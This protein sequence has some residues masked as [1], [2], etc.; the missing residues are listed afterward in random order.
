MR[1]P[2]LKLAA[3]LIAAVVAMVGQTSAQDIPTL[4]FSRQTAAEDNLWLMLAKPELAPNLNKAYKMEWS[5][6]RASEAAY[7]AYEGGQ[8]DFASVSGNSAIAAAAAGID[9]KIIATLS[10]ESQN[11]AH[12]KFLVKKD[13]PGKIADL[14]GGTIGIVGYRSAVE[15]WAREGVKSG[16]L[17]PDRDVTF[18]VVP[19]PQVPDAVRAGRIMAGA[20]VDAFA[21]G[22]IAQG[23][24]K[25]LFTSKTG[26][27]FDEELIVIVARPSTLK[28]YP[29]AVKAF[30]AD[31]VAVTAYYQSHLQ[32]ARQALLDAKLVGLPPQI[33]FNVPDYVRDPTLRPNLENMIKQQQVLVSSG[34]QEKNADLKTVVDPSYLPAN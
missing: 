9:L 28:Q 5:Q 24:L 23:D 22:A 21:M 16:G 18:A 17:D 1:M 32:E 15:L 27:P 19:F 14:K 10:R 6:L 7:K 25:T 29:A 2:M 13:G 4:R 26:M 30:L 33:Y 8:I 34:F 20:A 3:T 11:G 31:L 12:T